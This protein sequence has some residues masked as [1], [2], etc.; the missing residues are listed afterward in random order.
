MASSNFSLGR[1]PFSFLAPVVLGVCFWGLILTV[2][3]AHAEPSA[4]ISDL[5]GSVNIGVSVE[6]P[7]QPARLEQ[8]VSSGQIVQTGTDGMVELKLPDGSVVRLG[9]SSRY[10]IQVAA[11]KKHSRRFSA[12]LFFGRI[13]SRVRKVLRAG[14]GNFD[15]KTP[16][17]V[18][19]VRGTAYDVEIKKDQSAT[20]AVFDGRVGVAPPV[21]QENASHDEVTW[22]TEVSEQQWEE[23]IVQKLQKLQI[24][25]DGTPGEPQPLVAADTDDWIRFNLERDRQ[26][27][28]PAQ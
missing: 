7:W 28:F 24:Q 14:R 22:P 21:L 1:N 12:R 9:A 10:Q 5:K 4:I 11:F 3:S 8:P 13:W 17:A 15:L 2:G 20:I 23:I 19:G 16:T 27:G 26:Q 25:A 18:V 6:G